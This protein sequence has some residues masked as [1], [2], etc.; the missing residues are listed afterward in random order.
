MNILVTGS[1]GLVGSAVVE[2]LDSLDHKVI[3]VDNDSRKDFFGEAGSTTWNLDRLLKKTKNFHPIQLDIR[4]HDGID[5]LFFQHR[6]DGVIHLASQPA[7]DFSYRFP[8][9]DFGVNVVGTVNLLDATRQYCPE[10]PFIF[11]STSKVYG[12]AVN[13]FDFKELNTRYDYSS[14]WMRNGID[15]NC[16]IDQTLHSLFGADKAAADLIC[17]EYFSYFGLRGAVLRPGC[18]TGAGSSGV[19]LH[20]FLNYLIKCVLEGKTY[21]VFGYKMKQVRDNLH[22]YD[23]ATI[24]YEVIKKPPEKGAVYNIGGCRENSMSIIEAFELAK[25]MTGKEPV[26]E[27]KEAPRTGDHLVYITDANRFKSD[28][29]GWKMKYNLEMIFDDIIK[30]YQDRGEQNG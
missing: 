9:V 18:L 19:E 7:H 29:P 13:E 16:R 14:L 23:V 27:Y 4:D 12:T 10:A 11:T 3:G 1:S 2:L 26:Y 28:Y 30:G 24:C 8:M 15:E 20:S 5:L 22:A 21:N 17:Q 25:K 6:F